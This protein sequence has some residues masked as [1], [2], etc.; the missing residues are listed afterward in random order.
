MDRRTFLIRGAAAIAAVSA[1]AAS[2]NT[3]N[4]APEHG[5]SKE[6][7]ILAAVQEHLLPPGPD[8]PGAADVNALT[9]LQSVLADPQMDAADREFI[10]DG[11]ARLDKTAREME[12]KEFAALASGQRETVLRRVETT[13]DG[14]HWIAEILN[15]IFEALLGDPVYGGNPGGIGWKWLGHRP[16][17]PRPPS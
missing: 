12:G 6:W 5:L 9:Y 10:K 16:G 11:L 17:F 8:S 7:Q 1:P 13:K 3:F 2:A 4:T 15:Y 14:E